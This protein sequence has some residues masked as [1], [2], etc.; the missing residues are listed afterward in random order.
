MPRQ[1]KRYDKYLTFREASLDEI[2][3]WQSALKWFVQ[4]LAYSKGNRPLVLKSPAHT[5]RVRLLLEAF[6]EARFI[7]IHRNPYDVFVRRCIRPDRPFRG[8]RCSGPTCR[9]L[10]KRR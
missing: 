5:G 1:A 8:G 9:T 6:P 10:R 7:H 4:K 2:A 3:R